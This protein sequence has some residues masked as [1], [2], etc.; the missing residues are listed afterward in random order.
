M[1]PTKAWFKALLYSY[2]VEHNRKR[3]L[4]PFFK[5]LWVLS[6][7]GRRVRA[8]ARAL[9]QAWWADQV[10]QI[11]AEAEAWRQHLI[12]RYEAEIAVMEDP[13]FAKLGSPQAEAETDPCRFVAKYFPDANGSLDMSYFIVNGPIYLRQMDLRSL[14]ELKDEVRKVS[15]LGWMSLP[16]GGLF[17]GWFNI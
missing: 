3:L 10:Q 15:H 4:H 12:R 8:D 2:G 6:R 14:N 9:E 13:W 7:Q 5:P 1:R 16:D 17:V 11:T